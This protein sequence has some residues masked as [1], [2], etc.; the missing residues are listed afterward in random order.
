MKKCG[1]IF[2]TDTFEYYTQEIIVGFKYSLF[3]CVALNMFNARN[4]L[5]YRN[6]GVIHLNGIGVTCLQ[7]HKV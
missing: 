3:K 2:G 4:R 7:G 6:H 5:Q 1:V